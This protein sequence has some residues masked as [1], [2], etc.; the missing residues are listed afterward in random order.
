MIYIISNE[1]NPI[2]LLCLYVETYK[3]N[4]YEKINSSFFSSWN[5]NNVQL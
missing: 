4:Y 5:A 3:I 1:I 2:Y